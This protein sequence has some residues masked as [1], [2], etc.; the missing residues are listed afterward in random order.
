MILAPLAQ[1]MAEISGRQIWANTVGIV[2]VTG[3][4]LILTFIVGAMFGSFVTGLAMKLAR[5]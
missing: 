2:E 4:T 5:R 3:W 1:D